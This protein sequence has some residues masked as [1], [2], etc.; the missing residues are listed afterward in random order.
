MGK[1]E[2]AIFDMDGLMVDTE[3]LYFRAESEVARR[4]GKSFNRDVMQKM[5]GHKAVRSI[6]IMKETLGLDGSPDEVEALRDRL[7]EDLLLQGVK[8]MRGLLDLLNWLE[9]KGFRKA[10]ATSSKPAFK[11]IIFE[12]LHLHDRFETVVTAEEIS[13]GKPSPEIYHVAL[14]R[15]ALDPLQC[16]VMED[17][18]PG[19]K[20]AKGAGCFCIIVPN[21]FTENQD[22]SG[23]DLVAPHLFH[24]DVR[25]L[26]A[27]L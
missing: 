4:Y 7:Y 8:P 22:F 16:I 12:H 6:Q 14:R 11:D 5:M 19:L 13:E 9:N 10:V 1:I 25:R 26:F 23:A 27:E 21:E 20:A 2:A 15:L 17:S 3:G 18:V 24:K